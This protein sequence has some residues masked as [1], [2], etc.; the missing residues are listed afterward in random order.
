MTVLV[1][2]T[3]IEADIVVEQVGKFNRRKAAIF[4]DCRMKILLSLKAGR[5]WS[6]TNKLVAGTRRQ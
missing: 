3:V 2:D 6:A 5:L 4:E 1:A